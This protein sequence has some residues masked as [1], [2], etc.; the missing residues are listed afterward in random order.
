M[1]TSLDFIEINP[2]Q[3]ELGTVI[4]LHGLGADGHD[5]VPV[6]QELN[7][8]SFLPI[9]FIFP[10]AP[11]RPV[12]INNGYVM[13]AW[14]DITSMSIHQRFDVEGI[15]ES[16]K[17]V[18]KLIELEHKRGIPSHKIILAG[19]SQGAALALCAGLQYPKPLGG[20]VA[21]SGYLPAADKILENASAENFTTPIFIGHGQND[22]VVPYSLGLK[23]FELLQANKYLAK[24]WTY[25]IA[26][27]V[28]G[29][30]I[31]DIA[32]W[33]KDIYK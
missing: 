4:W 23:T 31:G 27:S 25:P 32:E 33:L 14:F 15:A 1:K 19:F 18:E 29:E 13:R 17:L 7:L 2:P 20:I 9:R 22:S 30:E 24:L 5:F 11:L 10:H 16:G 8:P 3:K 6:V 26:H 21:L 28:N 12:T